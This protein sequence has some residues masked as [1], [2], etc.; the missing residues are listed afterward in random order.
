MKQILLKIILCITFI[1]SLGCGLVLVAHVYQAKD[2]QAK[3]EKLAQVQHMRSVSNAPYYAPNQQTESIADNSSQVC[4]APLVY[5]YENMFKQNP[6]MV[7]WIAIENTDFSYPVMQSSKRPNY[8]LRRNFEGKYSEYGTP[9]LSETCDIAASDNLVIHG[10]NIE[11]GKMFGLLEE[12]KNKAFWEQHPIITLNT[13]NEKRTY[14]IFCVSLVTAFS[15]LVDAF[16]YY[17]FTQANTAE[18]YNN[19]IKNV[20]KYAI[21]DTGL[22]P[23][24]E[25]QLITLSTCE[26]SQE[27]GRLIVV[28]YLNEALD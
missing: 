13:K 5:E 25:V 22:S 7:A 12:Y 27:N 16:P 17:S 15:P 8:Y 19:Y 24:N 6:N 28:A 4:S 10:H 20:K 2:A 26:Y 14:Q 3:L 23:E 11:N 1:V 9:Y 21:Y 18:E